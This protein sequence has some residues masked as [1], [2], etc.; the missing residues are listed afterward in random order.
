MHHVLVLVSD[1]VPYNVSCP[2]THI[3]VILIFLSFHCFAASL[4]VID[5]VCRSRDHPCATIPDHCGFLKFA[6]APVPVRVVCG[7]FVR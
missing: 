6:I 2:G 7:R 1:S 5:S 3:E 4:F